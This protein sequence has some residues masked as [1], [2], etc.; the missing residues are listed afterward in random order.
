MKIIE[1]YRE[2]Y[3]PPMGI[4]GSVNRL[5]KYLGPKCLAGVGTI[6]LTHSG[7]LN[8]R[9]RRETTRSRG[10][11]SAVV[12]SLGIYHSRWRGETAWIELFVDNITKRHPRL[13]LLIPPYRDVL[14]AHTLCHEVGHHLHATRHPEYRED[15]AVADEWEQKLGRRFFNRVY[16]YLWPLVLLHRATKQTALWL[17][18]T[19]L[20][21]GRYIVTSAFDLVL[22]INSGN[23]KRIFCIPNA[24]EFIASMVFFRV[25][26][27]Q[28]RRFFLEQ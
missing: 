19:W 6:V 23:P 17:L 4:R 28:Y 15:E 9:R 2:S 1:H 3:R 5:V 12:S 18:L 20:L 14:V 10:R 27:V 25:A 24:L 16:W 26:Y 11:K 8:R 7:Y 22:D 21:V 13:L